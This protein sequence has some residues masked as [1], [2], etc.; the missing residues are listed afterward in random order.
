MFNAGHETFVKLAIRFFDGTALIE[1]PINSVHL[2]ITTNS[3]VF[4]HWI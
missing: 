2:L 4:S 1:R 3:G